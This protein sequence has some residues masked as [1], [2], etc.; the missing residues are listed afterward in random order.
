MQRRRTIV[1]RGPFG[2]YVDP[3]QHAQEVLDRIL[4]RRKPLTEDAVFLGL[5]TLLQQKYGSKVFKAVK[6]SKDIGGYRYFSFSPDI[7]LLE[8]RP[9]GKVVAYELKGYR[10]AG[11]EMKPPMHYEGID[12]ALAMLMNPMGSPLSQGPAGSVFDSVYLAHPEGSHVEGLSALLDQCTP[13]GLVVMSYRGIREVVPPKP[14]PF[15]NPE[16]KGMFLSN[17]AA[18]DSY[19]RFR[20]NAV[21]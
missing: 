20:V 11:K 5:Y 6:A 15:L 4:S 12:Q 14:N 18:L 13:I 1:G 17:L 19:T 7:D 16:L 3:H 2:H 21:Q 9:N 8:V 10:R